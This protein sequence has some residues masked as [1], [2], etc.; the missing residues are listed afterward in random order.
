[1]II[2]FRLVS[3][4][5]A[6]IPLTMETLSSNVP[7]RLPKLLS[8]VEVLAPIGVEIQTPVRIQ[9]V[10]MEGPNAQREMQAPPKETQA[11]RETPKTQQI[12][13]AENPQF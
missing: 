2:A 6:G 7:C 10:Q 8:D 3:Y 11:W 1:M 4:S 13:N 5:Q 9:K 12:N